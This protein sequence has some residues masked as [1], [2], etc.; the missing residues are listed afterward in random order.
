MASRFG[1]SLELLKSEFTRNID[2]GKDIVG[3]TVQG[4]INA[5]RTLAQGVLEVGPV[6]WHTVTGFLGKQQEFAV[7]ERNGV[8]DG[9]GNAVGNTITELRNHKF[10]SAIYTLF[11][12]ILPD[13]LVRDAMQGHT[14]KAL[15]HGA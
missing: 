4:I 1:A 7:Q 5:G 10:L 2:G 3:Q 14:V 13:G 9:V 8:L 12:E 6:A 15:P 11:S